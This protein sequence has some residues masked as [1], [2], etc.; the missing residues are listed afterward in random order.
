MKQDKGIIFFIIL[1]I[2]IIVSIILEHNTK[3]YYTI[4]E[5]FK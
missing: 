4:M 1:Q 2:I 3:I 5:L